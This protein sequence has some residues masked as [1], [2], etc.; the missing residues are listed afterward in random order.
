LVLW[1][2]TFCPKSDF[3]TLIGNYF[4]GGTAHT[5]FWNLVELNYS[6]FKIRG[7]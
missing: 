3:R 7:A 5:T 6:L 1:I 2:L 4:N